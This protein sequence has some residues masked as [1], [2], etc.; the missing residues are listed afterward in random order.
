MKQRGAV[1][2]GVVHATGMA[3]YVDHYAVLGVPITATIQ[4]IRQAYRRRIAEEHADRHGGDA[5]AVD[6]TR[7]LNLARDVLSDPLRRARFERERRAQCSRPATGDPLFDTVARTFGATPSSGPGPA[8]PM[9]E[10]PQ[11]AKGVALG[12]FAAAA[13]LSVGFGIAAAIKSA[14]SNL[15]R[16]EG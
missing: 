6:R 4:E 9:G 10:V 12:V 5:V 8:Q 3:G 1:R 15:R 2:L 7:D 11:W 14:V 16:D 13:A